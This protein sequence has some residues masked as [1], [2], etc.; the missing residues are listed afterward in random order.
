MIPLPKEAQVS[1]VN[2]MV[3]DDFDGDGNLDVLING[4]DY[5]T[6]VSIGRFD[7]LNGLLLKGDGKG[8]F[9]PRSILQS[10]IYIPGNGKAMVKL[11]SAK[12]DYLI[13]ASQHEGPLKMFELQHKTTNIPVQPSDSYAI[14]NYRNG[15]LEK[16]ELYYGTS[17]LSQ[18]ARFITISENV[19][20]ASIFNNK[21]EKRTLSFNSHR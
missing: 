7:A 14:I 15:T 8:C 19:I 4:N 18:S 1:V 5:G 21:M 16:K 2:G 10:G 12:G 20:S 11:L 3:A 13:A 17:F 9:S 6:A